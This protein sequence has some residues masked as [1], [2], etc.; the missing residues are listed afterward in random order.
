M[1][2]QP[3]PDPCELHE[4][5][6]VWTPVRPGP[7]L[8]RSQIIL[9]EGAGPTEHARCSIDSPLSA[10]M[11][12][13][14]CV[15][16]Q[17]VCE[18]TVAE[19]RRCGAEGWEMSLGELKAFIALLFAKGVHYGKNMDVEDLWSK[20]WGPPFFSTTMSRNR[21]RE[22][23][24]F[25]RFD[26]KDTS[27]SD[28]FVLI[29]EV[30]DRLIKNS[31]A[32]FKPGAEITVDE[33]LFPTKS[34]CPFTQYMPDKPG[35]FGIKFCL[36]ADVETKYMLNGF[37]YLGRDQSLE[38]SVVLK[39]VDSFLE[40]GRNVTTT[41][42]FTSLPLAHKLLDRNTSLVGSVSKHLLPPCAHQRAALYDTKVM[43]LDGATLTIYG[44]ER[45]N[46]CILSTKHKSVEVCDDAKKTPETVHYYN[47]TKVGV[48]ALDRMLRQYSVRAATRRWPVSVFYNMLDI[49]AFNACVLYRGCVD[50]KMT[51]RQFILEL[52]KQLRREKV[53]PPTWIILPTM[54]KKRA[55]CGV[56]RRCS[57][58]KTKKMCMLC[59]RTVCGQCTA[60]VH[61]VCVD[62]V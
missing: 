59:Q 31:I 47:R 37:P 11:C 44:E 18:C 39:L 35:K 3:S 57:Q 9:T 45:K 22:I 1:S 12:L 6:T 32:C 4:D 33:Q 24:R 41:S 17:H 16:L 58:N 50:T 28:M 36:A 30:W 25:L 61:S 54:P 20:E 46:V 13:I 15:M 8:E 29:S 43:Q 26:Q 19:A 48:E 51:R 10:F 56:K 42:F 14:D 34:R 38:E 27:E 21:F 7:R 40:E 2:A 49:A 53:I 23:M 52:C 55:T 60:I 5:G 62:C